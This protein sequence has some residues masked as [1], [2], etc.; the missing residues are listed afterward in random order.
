MKL[1]RVYYVVATVGA[2][3]LIVLYLAQLRGRCEGLPLRQC[4]ADLW[5]WATSPSE[6]ARGPVKEPDAG[7]RSRL[8]TGSMVLNVRE[9]T[10]GS[11]GFPGYHAT[12]AFSIENRSGIGLGIGIRYGDYTIGACKVHDVK[13]SYDGGRKRYVAPRVSGVTAAQPDDIVELKKAAAPAEKLDWLMVDGKVAGTFEILNNDCHS[14]MFT[15]Q[16]SVSVFVP[17]ILAAGSESLDL[18]LSADNVP[19]RRLGSR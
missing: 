19:I 16:N 17:I 13:I 3:V 6:T 12:A 7:L 11:R 9:V 1:S 4:V 5:A 2:L 8:K 14:E 18:V 10:I 15:D